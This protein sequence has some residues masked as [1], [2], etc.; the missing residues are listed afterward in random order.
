MANTKYAITEESKT[1]RTGFWRKVYRIRAL[2][3][4]GADVKKGDFGGWVRDEGSLADY[5]TC[6][7]YDDA[8]CDGGRVSM[9]GKL[10]N[11]AECLSGSLVSG[12][13]VVR[14]RASIRGSSEVLDYGEVYGDA[15]ISSNA[16]VFDHAKV[17]GKNRVT[18]NRRVGGNTVLV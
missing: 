16:T 12:Y 6:W 3:D 10:R 4:I 14:D 5:G 8:V 17:G 7:I 13:A 1:P 9:E 11:E 18:W 2:R 15:I